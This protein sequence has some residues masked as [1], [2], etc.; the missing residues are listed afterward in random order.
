[1][2]VKLQGKQSNQKNIYILPFKTMEVIAN[3]CFFIHMN[4]KKFK[5]KNSL[6]E[7]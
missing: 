1:M 2:G 7:F 5:P 4:V 3:Y 6:M